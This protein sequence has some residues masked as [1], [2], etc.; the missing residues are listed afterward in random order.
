[1]ES[2][3]TPMNFAPT[4]VLDFTKR[5]LKEGDLSVILSF[6]AFFSHISAMVAD[7]QLNVRRVGIF[8]SFFLLSL[9]PGLHMGYR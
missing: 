1:M 6:W 2:S 4:I 5:Y 9:F 8:P 7:S 3:S